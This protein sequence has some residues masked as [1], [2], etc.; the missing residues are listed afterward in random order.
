MDRSGPARNRS[1]RR[2]GR[3]R[4]GRFGPE[5]RNNP[6]GNLG[7]RRNCRPIPGTAQP[8]A[9]VR[10][11]PRAHQ[12]NQ[13]KRGSCALEDRI[14]LVCRLNGIATDISGSGT[15]SET[16]TLDRL[17]AKLNLLLGRH[18]RSR[19]RGTAGAASGSASTNESTEP[20]TSPAAGGSGTVRAGSTR[21]AVADRAASET[22]STGSATTIRDR[23]ISTG[24]DRES[25]RRRAGTEG[26]SARIRELE[27][28][29]RLAAVTLKNTQ[30]LAERRVVSQSE[31][32]IAQGQYD[33]PLAKLRGLH[34]DFA[35]ELEGCKLAVKKKQAELDEAIAE[36]EFAMALVARNERL[37]QKKTGMVAAEDVAQA[38]SKLQSGDAHVRVKRVDL[39]EAELQCRKVERW[40]ESVGKIIETATKQQ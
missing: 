8:A 38:R 12:R 28:Q 37:N 40:R 26:S 20:S 2:W 11:L 21:T 19:A 36:K 13:P 30:K 17:E 39:E 5:H 3:R 33:L 35:L 27:V 22:V 9:S 4:R 15:T 24:S 25:W 1:L 6:G 18:E 7:H 16:P 34:E 14:D 31:L 32:E 23:P 10:R 29:L